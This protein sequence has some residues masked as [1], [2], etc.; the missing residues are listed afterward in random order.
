[1]NRPHFLIIGRVLSRSRLDSFNAF[2]RV[3]NR[4]SPITGLTGNSFGKST[5]ATTPR[6]FQACLRVMF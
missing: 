6:T 4:S 1:M 5:P 3:D 2:H